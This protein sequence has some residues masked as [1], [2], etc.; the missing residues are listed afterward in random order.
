MAKLLKGK[1]IEIQ[2]ITISG[3]TGNVIVLGDLDMSDNAIITTK[4]TFSDNELVTKSYVDTNGGGHTIAVDGVSLTNRSI[5]EFI[6]NENETVGDDNAVGD[7][8]QILL[9]LAANLDVDMTGVINGDI[10]SYNSTTQKYEPQ[11]IVAYDDILRNSELNI[12]SNTLLSTIIPQG[13]KL[14]QVWYEETS[15]NAA[16]NVSL[17]TSSLGNNIV[18]A[19]TI[20]AN[21]E[22]EAVLVAGN[23]GSLT[24]DTSIYVS[25]SAW[26]SGVVTLHFVMI[27][28]L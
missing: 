20:G 22:G 14:T 2:T 17:G 25:S 10:I 16:G 26:G 4:T 15:N 13:Y 1:Q 24:Q 12:S 7:A 18:N 23:L 5:L 27:K 3:S 6:T 19:Q 28:I 9:K 8:T 21:A 11:N